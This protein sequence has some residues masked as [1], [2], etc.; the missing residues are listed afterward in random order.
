MFFSFETERETRELVRGRGREKSQV[1]SMPSMET[2][3]GLDLTTLSQNPEL[4][5]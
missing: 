2:N 3:V 1:D 4:D 5:A